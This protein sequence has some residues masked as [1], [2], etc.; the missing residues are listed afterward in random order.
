MIQVQCVTCVVH[1]GWS[2]VWRKSRNTP[3]TLHFFTSYMSQAKTCGYWLLMCSI[4]CKSN[5]NGWDIRYTV[6]C[7]VW[8]RERETKVNRRT[9]CLL[10]FRHRT[11]KRAHRCRKGQRTRDVGLKMIRTLRKVSLSRLQSELAY[12][13]RT[14]CVPPVA[15]CLCLQTPSPQNWGTPE[16]MNSKTIRLFQ[17]LPRHAA[18]S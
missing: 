9:S 15:S 11:L 4:S 2:R 6:Y 14:S 5:K 10:P 1:Q 12:L 18:T 17:D 13:V 16:L 7:P 8:E 3:D